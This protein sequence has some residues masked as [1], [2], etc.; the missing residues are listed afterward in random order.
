MRETSEERIRGCL[1][2]YLLF[3]ISFQKLLPW[4]TKGGNLWYTL[5]C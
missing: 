3:N 4:M 5:I 1:Y 2:S